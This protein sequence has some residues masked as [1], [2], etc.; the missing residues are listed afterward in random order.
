MSVPAVMASIQLGIRGIITII[1]TTMS[2]NNPLIW[3]RIPHGPYPLRL[4]HSAQG[5]GAIHRMMV[6]RG[7]SP[8]V[9]GMTENC[10]LALDDLRK[11]PCIRDLFRFLARV[12]FD[13]L[14]LPFLLVILRPFLFYLDIC[15][16]YEFELMPLPFM[17][18]PSFFFIVLVN[19]ACVTSHV[20]PSLFYMS[21]L[22]VVVRA[23][24]WVRKCSKVT[25]TSTHGR[26]Y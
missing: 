1:T 14:I 23:K 18:I 13:V 20:I 15:S 8:G 24:Q 6:G 10:V 7:C 5:R 26:L 25:S 22:Q 4:G 17:T 19:Y 12:G 2:H 16:S 3:I 21:V 11:H 9:E